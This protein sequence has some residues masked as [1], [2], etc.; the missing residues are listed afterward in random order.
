ME[1]TPTLKPSVSPLKAA[2]CGWQTV[3]GYF[4]KSVVFIQANL[5]RQLEDPNRASVLT[6]VFTHPGHFV[7]A[8]RSGSLPSG[9]LE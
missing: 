6:S 5:P 1:I 4:R 9:T 8:R 2:E 3:K 7:L